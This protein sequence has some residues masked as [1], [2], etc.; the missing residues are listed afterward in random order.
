MEFMTL[1]GAEMFIL[2]HEREPASVKKGD[3]IHCLYG[4]GSEI[5]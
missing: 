2:L 1:T 4:S 3:E 5:H